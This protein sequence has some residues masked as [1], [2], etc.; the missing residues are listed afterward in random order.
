MTIGMSTRVEHV[1]QIAVGRVQPWLRLC[2]SSL[3]VVSS[4]LVDWSSS[5]A[6]S[7]S[8]LRLWSSSL[9]ETSSSLADGELFVGAAVLLDQRLEVFLR[10]RPARA[11]ARRR[12]WASLLLRRPRGLL[13]AAFPRSV[14]GAS[15][16]STTKRRSSRRGAPR[17][18]PRRCHTGAW[19]HPAPTCTPLAH[20]LGALLRACESATRSG[21]SSPSRAILRRLCSRLSR[22]GLEV[23]AGVPAELEDLQPLVDDDARAARTGSRAGDRSLRRI[24]AGRRRARRQARPLA[25]FSASCRSSC[26]AELAGAAP[27]ARRSCCAL[28]TGD[29]ELAEAPRCSPCARAGGSRGRSGS[30]GRWPAP[31]SGAPGRSR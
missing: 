2:S 16:N 1:H 22:R 10:R 28:S 24:E 6:V 7:S 23:G 5:F 9:L 31:S 11:P 19:R 20:R 25:G 27:L 12:A 30:S 13:T 18:G 14:Q 4:S 26:E 21:A 17:R 15:S 8:S 29:E 3:T